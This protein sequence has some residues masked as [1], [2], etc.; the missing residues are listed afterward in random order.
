[1]RSAVGVLLVLACS[2]PSATAAEIETL[3]VTIR[4][5]DR[6]ASGSLEAAKALRELTTADAGVLPRVLAAFRGANP[7]AVNYLR[8]AAETIADRSLASG[9]PLPAKA[10]EAFIVDRANDPRARRLGYELLLRVDPKAPDRLIPGMLT[11]P[12][13]EFRRDA[14]A[15]LIDLGDRLNRERQGDLATTLYRR[16][17]AGAT[18]D[19]QVKTLVAALK[20]L[21]HQV[22]L[23]RHFGFLTRWQIVG[24][25]DNR[26]K[27]GFAVVYRPEVKLDLKARLKGQLGPVR[28]QPFSTDQD[29]GVL[30]IAKTIKPYKGAVMYATTSFTIDE[31]RDI[32]LRL[33]TPNA[34]KLWLNGRLLFAREEYHR[35]MILDQYRVPGR[36]K[37]GI[38]TILL[39]VCQNEQAEDWAQ[40]YQF[41]L[42]VC[43]ASGIAVPPSKPARGGKTGAQ[44]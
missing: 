42:R 30:D 40:R 27:K 39:K 15:R 24:P 20:K 3:L 6:D 34:W 28:W 37:T 10:I 29:Y 36:L 8:G 13:P 22:D 31:A 21:G 38:N 35:G 41:Q 1:M 9:K 11:D 7:L 12:N 43:D 19:D 33:G 16:A 14:V 25:F 23:P 4:S 2:A 5:I 26:E 32:E 17:L 44:P 18:H